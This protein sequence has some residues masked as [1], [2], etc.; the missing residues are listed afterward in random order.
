M[1][2]ASADFC[3]YQSIVLETDKMSVSG[4]AEVEFVEVTRVRSRRTNFK[5]LRVQTSPEEV[6]IQVSYFWSNG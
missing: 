5:Q 2:G 4:N 1:T 3:Q 6:K